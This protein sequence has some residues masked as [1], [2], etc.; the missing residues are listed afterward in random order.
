M[1]IETQITLT[2]LLNEVLVDEVGLNK[3]L[4]LYKHKLFGYTLTICIYVFFLA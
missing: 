3:L 1:V 2:A 4:Y